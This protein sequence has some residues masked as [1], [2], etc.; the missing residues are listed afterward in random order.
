MFS[1]HFPITQDPALSHAMEIAMRYV[2][3]VG[4]SE[5]FANPEALVATGISTAWESG[6]RHPIA[7]ANAGILCA[8]RTANLGKLPSMYARLV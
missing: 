7:L 5:R 2:R 8:E 6:L 4:L 1:A 3:G